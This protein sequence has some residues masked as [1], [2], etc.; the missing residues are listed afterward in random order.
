MGTILKIS[1]FT[2]NAFTGLE[3]DLLGFFIN[4]HVD[5]DVFGKKIDR[6]KDNVEDF[7]ILHK[8]QYMVLIIN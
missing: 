5:V 1:G 7:R 4:S 2:N 8:K 6:C 3:M